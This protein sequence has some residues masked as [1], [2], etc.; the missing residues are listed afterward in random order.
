MLTAHA[1]DTYAHFKAFAQGY[2]GAP[3]VYSLNSAGN[4]D[5][6]AAHIGL[7]WVMYPLSPAVAAATLLGDFALAQQVDDVLADHA[8][9]H[10]GL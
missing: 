9:A 10:R 7:G 4:V 2:T 3:V 6:A 5:R 1:P 8:W